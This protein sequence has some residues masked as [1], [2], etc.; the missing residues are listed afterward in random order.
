M[1]A[2][3][4]QWHMR[5]ALAPLLFDAEERE[6]GEAR[7]ES[8]VGPAQR[9]EGAERKARTRR[10]TDGLPVHHFRGPLAH[11][12]TLT[13]NHCIEPSLGPEHPIK[14]LSQPTAIQERA[15]QLLGISL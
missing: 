14:L 11:L 10:T 3:Y 7:R 9:S 5:K 6:E 1:L 15:F 12:A 4:V 2:H 13:R 8:P